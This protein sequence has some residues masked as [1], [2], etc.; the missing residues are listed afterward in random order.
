[1]RV[2]GVKRWRIHAEARPIGCEGQKSTL[3]HA[4]PRV[5]RA[6]PASGICFS[7]DG[8]LSKAM[9]KSKIVAY[10]AGDSASNLIWGFCAMYLMYFYTDVAC[11]PVAASGA[12]LLIGKIA[13]GFADIAGGWLID[14]RIDA[15][16]RARPFIKIFTLPLALA[17]IATFT[18]PFRDP[19]LAVAWALATNVVLNI[20]YSLVNVAYGAMT[21]LIAE[22]PSDL[23]DLASS[24]VVGAM[25]ATLLASI[26]VL[27]IVTF[28]GGGNKLIGFPIYVAGLMLGVLALFWVT[29]RFCPEIVRPAAAPGRFTAALGRIVRNPGWRVITL[30]MVFDCIGLTMTLGSVPYFAGN[31]LHNV[32]VISAGFSMFA[33]GA[34]LGGAFAG[35]ISGRYSNRQLLVGASIAEVAGLLCMPPAT[36]NLLLLFVPLAAYTVTLG[37]KMAGSYGALA[38]V[39]D[40]APAGISVGIAYSVN[41]FAYKCA[42]GIGAAS[43]GGALAFGHYDPA[44]AQQAGPALR[45]IMAGGIYLPAIAASCS[46]LLALFLPSDRMKP[47]GAIS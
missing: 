20:L 14:R 10:G 29:Y 39:I 27:E 22:E 2:N 8:G 33:I 35:Q 3:G 4:D 7:T 41:S 9:R 19:A 1:M 15:R 21:N 32:A 11:L 38:E 42:A 30:V 46:G 12:I 43:I 16:E 37:V 45:A 25:L 17:A 28:A 40:S 47:A 23:N 44:A 13:S 6:H 36:G 31:I 24:R 5:Y 26:G 34:L 18:A